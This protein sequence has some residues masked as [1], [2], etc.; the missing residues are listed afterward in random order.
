MSAYSFNNLE[1]SSENDFLP[2]M[3]YNRQCLQKSKC[4]SSYLYSVCL[5]QE[6][7]NCDK[8]TGKQGDCEAVMSPTVDALIYNIATFLPQSVK[9]VSFK[10]KIEC[11]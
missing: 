8:A 3:L 11:S 5:S 6:V 2:F 1:F 9:L 10:N 4:L 7:L